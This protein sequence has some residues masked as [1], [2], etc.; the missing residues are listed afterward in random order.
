[1]RRVDHEFSSEFAA[2]LPVTCEILRKGNLTVHDAVYCINL[3]GSRGLKGGYRPDSDIDISL[4]V[5]SEMLRAAIDKAALLNA[6]IDTTIQNWHSEIELDTAAIF[7]KM[8]CGLMCFGVIHY[9]ELD[10][11]AAHLDCIGIFKTQKGFNGFV[12]EIGVDVQ[13]V[14][15]MIRVWARKRRT[16]DAFNAKPGV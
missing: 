4:L 11:K 1:L 8:G 3:G 13:R 16:S 9:S 12:P 2:R 7:D 10:C 14:L 15:P 5:D 6:V